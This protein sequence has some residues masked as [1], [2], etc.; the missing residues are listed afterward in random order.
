MQDRVEDQ[1]SNA[2]EN[3]ADREDPPARPPQVPDVPWLQTPFDQ[4]LRRPPPNLALLNEGPGWVPRPPASQVPD[5]RWWA[6]PIAERPW[7]AKPSR[8]AALLDLPLTGKQEV[9]QPPSVLVPDQSLAPVRVEERNGRIALASDRDSPLGSAEADFNAWREPVADHVQELLAGDF[10][11]G[12]NHGRARDR[13]VALGDLLPGAVADVKERQFRI[14]YEV[15]RLDGL[16]TA[17]RTG[18]NDMPALNA[19]VLEDLSRLL[20]AL[21]SGTDKL[22]RWAKFRRAASD[23][24]MREG[25]ADPTVVSEV[26]DELAAKMEEQPTYFDPELPATFR[27][28]A[29]AVRDPLGATRA[30]VFGAV[31]SIEN[32]LSFLGRKA[33]GIATNVADAVEKHISKVV[34]GSLILGISA[35]AIRLSG[36]LPIEWAW[37]KPLLSALAKLAGG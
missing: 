15:E 12:T 28:L 20:H 3:A 18:G 36:A 10:R 7:M 1:A 19:A 6:T 5:I 31:R 26:L 8:N 17:Y 16:I 25:E 14:G 32:L 34:A 27:W 37:L 4:P 21:R 35:L 22:E 29:E 11:E 2:A 13:L 23:D 24:P 33:L 9:D 30:V